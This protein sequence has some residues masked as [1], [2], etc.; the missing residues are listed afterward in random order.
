MLVVMCVCVCVCVT[1]PQADNYEVVA[2]SLVT[3]AP[4][5][6]TDM[7]KEWTPNTFAAVF[8][9]WPAA[10]VAALLEHVTPE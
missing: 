7:C 2:Q 6:V 8:A 3:W 1:Y 9:E 5:E 10:K 4:E